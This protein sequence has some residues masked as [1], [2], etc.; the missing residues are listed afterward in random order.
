MPPGVPRYFR[1]R[2]LIER[3]PD[4]PRASECS[5]L[6]ATVK[7]PTGFQPGQIFLPIMEIK[8]EDFV[9]PVQEQSLIINHPGGRRKAPPISGAR[10]SKTAESATAEL[11]S[12]WDFEIA[13]V[14]RGSLA[15][16]ESPLYIAV[17]RKEIVTLRPNRSL[18]SRE[19]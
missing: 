14:L 11:T 17:Q 19:P 15:K 9:L 18:Q 2:V 10:W 8:G 7:R 12:R 5:R 1:R 6:L 13:G 4:L 16:P 3:R